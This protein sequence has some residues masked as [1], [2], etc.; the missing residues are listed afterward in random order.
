M[1]NIVGIFFAQSARINR[2]KERKKERQTNRQNHDDA[3]EGQRSSP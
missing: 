3:G 2:K 1:T